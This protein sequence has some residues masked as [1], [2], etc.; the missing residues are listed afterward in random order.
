MKRLAQEVEDELSRWNGFLAALDDVVGRRVA[1]RVREVWTAIQGEIGALMPLPV[2]SPGGDE[3]D[4]SLSWDLKP[5]LV[6]LQL[7][8][9]GKYWWYALD[10]STG[11]DAGIEDPGSLDGPL[12]AELI[13]WLKRLCNGA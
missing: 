13:L 8:G 11:A 1:S 3:A 9:D 6:T 5:W 12:D 2:A 4:F 10:R 7:R